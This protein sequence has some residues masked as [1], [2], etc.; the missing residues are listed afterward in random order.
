M[1]ASDGIG[2]NPAWATAANRTKIFALSIMSI[3][4]AAD[5]F[6]FPVHAPQ[7]AEQ[8]RLGRAS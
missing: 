6:H 8:I 5:G 2:C 1:A 3:D 7:S 4:I